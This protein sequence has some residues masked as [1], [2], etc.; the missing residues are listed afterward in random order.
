MGYAGIGPDFFDRELSAMKYQIQRGFTLI[1]LMIVVA[2]IGILAAIALPQY[3]NYTIRSKVSEGLVLA[4]SAKS[5]IGEAFAS[6]STAGVTAVANN[7]NAQVPAVS[8][9]YVASITLDPASP[10]GITITYQTA[11]GGITQLAGANIITLTP[12]ITG[13]GPLVANYA[14]TIDWACSSATNN[15]AQSHMPAA[16]FEPGGS[17]LSQYAPTECQ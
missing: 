10:F 15:T 1:E 14:G 17:V 12:N 13:G 3:Q 7:W 11:A 6:N 9:K 16:V 2:I 5:A 4:D 8:S